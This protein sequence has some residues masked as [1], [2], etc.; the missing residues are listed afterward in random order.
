M[1]QI[2]IEGSFRILRATPGHITYGIW[3]NHGKAGDL[4]V[5]REEYVEFERRM[6]NAGFTLLPN[7]GSFDQVY[8]ENARRRGQYEEKP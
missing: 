7:I 2:D 8:V 3:I 5:R 1:K 6:E 4:T